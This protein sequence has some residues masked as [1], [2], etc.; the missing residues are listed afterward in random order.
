MGL[1]DIFKR[2]KEVEEK[3]AEPAAEEIHIDEVHE[4]VD[5][6]L[7]GK[8]KDRHEKANDLY[9]DIAAGFDKINASAQALEAARFE[10]EEKIG[11]VVNMTKELFV[12]RTQNLVNS[13]QGFHGKP[14][15]FKILKEFQEA[16]AEA[17]A[18]MASITPKQA[19]LLSTYFSKESSSVIDSIKE[20][21]EK[22]SVLKEFLD[23]EGETMQLAHRIR[24]KKEQ[25]SMLRLRLNSVE[26]EESGI[27]MRIRDLRSKTEKNLAEIDSIVKGHE[28]AEYNRLSEEMEKNRRMA[29]AIR[30]KI[31]EELSSVEKPLKK[32]EY[33]VS[34][35]YPILKEQEAI[36]DG[37]INR[38]FETVMKD[39][40]QSLKEAILLVRKAHAED[41]VVFKDKERERLDE[42]VSR[43]DT[44]IKAMKSDYLELEEQLKERERDRN[45]YAWAIER[46]NHLE[47]SI[48][49]SL[50]EISS[51]EKILVASVEDKAALKQE[52]V[53]QKQE[54]EDII[55]RSSGKKVSIV[56][57][58]SVKEDAGNN[59]P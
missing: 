19:Y 50:E 34:K 36:L 20:T 46:K 10:T 21:Q 28:H 15:D 49:R 22:V 54:L 56:V 30:A 1:L 16:A 6:T 39:T 40:E 5:Q 23:A 58:D 3:P 2:K 17:L 29:S 14:I 37:L 45:R 33:L 12:R 31:T 52:I 32:L 11:A 55:Y 26:K 4:W 44:G 53:R 25:Q 35:G 7:A 48:K 42:L 47:S 8:I 51:L 38:P 13:I 41:K 59:E 9:S 27:E 57:P 43:L 24:S 18:D